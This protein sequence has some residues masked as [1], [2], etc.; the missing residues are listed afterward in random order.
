MPVNKIFIFG[1]IILVAFAAGR[2]LAPTKIK[3]ETKIVEVEK[4]S[5]KSTTDTD[6]NKHKET[7]TVEIVRPDGTKETTTTT[8]EDTNTDRKTT[9]AKT[10]ES[11]KA[12]SQS[13]EET[14]S[15]SRT[16]IAALS[17]VDT[18]QSLN[19]LVYGVSISKEVLGPISIGV[20]GLSNKTY[21]ASVGVSF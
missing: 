14:R 7:K 18:S 15:S 21:G 17:G 13:R 9:T 11:K 19:P 10:E 6:R 1:A 12:E 2:W 5:E 16:S 4:K 20:W 3:T 8:V